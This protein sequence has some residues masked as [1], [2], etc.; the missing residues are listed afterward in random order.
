MRSSFAALAALSARVVCLSLIAAVSWNPAQAQSPKQTLDRVDAYSLTDVL[1]MTFNDPNRTKDFFNLGIDGTNIVWCTLTALDGIFCLDNKV[2]KHWPDPEES[3]TPINEVNCLDPALQLKN[4]ECTGM[5]VGLSGAI[6]L[7]G[8]KGN[9]HSLFKIVPKAPTAPCIGSSELSGSLYCARELYAG[10]PLI[11]DLTAIDGDVG[12]AFKPCPSCAVQSGILA[13]EAR[14]AVVFFP[15]PKPTPTSGAI[16]VANSQA[17]GLSGNEQALGGTLLQLQ[18]VNSI[19]SFVAVTTSTSRIRV[20][21]TNG[22]GSAFTAFNIAQQRAPSSTQC[23]FGTQNYGIVA[24]PQ[25]GR[26]YVTDRNFCQVLALDATVSPFT[27]ELTLSTADSSGTFPTRGP[28]LAPGINIDLADCAGICTFLTDDEG[29]AAASFSEVQLASGSNTDATAFQIKGIPDCRYAGRPEFPTNLE[30]VCDD[31]DAVVDPDNVDHPAGQFLNVTKLLPLQLRALFDDSGVPP[32]GLPPLLISPQ[33]RAQLRNNFVFAALFVITEPGVRFND[34]FT[35][36]YDVPLLEDVPASLGCFPDPE[37]LIA[38]DIS[39]TVSETFKSTSTDF[40]DDGDA[41]H[42]DTL[43]NTGCINP[44]KTSGYRI[45]LLPYNFEPT[46]D[47]YGPTFL[48][49]VRSVTEGNDAVF[50]RLVQNLYD[51]LDF[52]RREHACI[53]VD[54][55]LSATL[56]N[57][58]ASKWQNGKVKLDKCIEAAFAPKQSQ[59]DENCQSFVTQIT[60]YRDSLPATTSPTDVAN[61]LGEQK[62]RVDVILH[63]FN[64]RFL[65]S[66]PANGFCRE[67]DFDGN[68]LTCPDPWQ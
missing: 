64:T 62:A 26:V 17:L 63:V 65:P 45:S 7:A 10:R 5:T 59:G 23:D 33:Y 16:V 39:T 47:T 30:A 19:D 6:Y 42:V 22:A 32:S 27:K 38:W 29:N 28:T 48:S 54:S 3:Q 11:T 25:S 46:P 35:A 49:S 67:Q 50:A 15:D 66:I 56:C 43:T 9:G 24:S 2:V 36:L 51:D 12:A 31:A 14:K 18:N 68:P 53:Q 13:L 20:K 55:P 61:R 41:E 52:V 34:V 37:N 57:S 21:K 58:L 40:D 44:V 8:R 60:N 4:G 1:E